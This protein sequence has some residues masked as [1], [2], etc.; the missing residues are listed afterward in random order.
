V[1]VF[2]AHG[3]SKSLLNVQFRRAL[4]PA[5]KNFV[6]ADFVEQTVMRASS[7]SSSM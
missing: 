7:E 6:G 1:N 4:E 3:F 2:F 5:A